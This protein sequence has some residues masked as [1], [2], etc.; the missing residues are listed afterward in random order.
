ME[1]VESEETLWLGC[2][3]CGR[4]Y[5]QWCYGWRGLDRRG[6]IVV[7]WYYEVMW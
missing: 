6:G 4:G 7:E 1:Q 5:L 2:V 3:C